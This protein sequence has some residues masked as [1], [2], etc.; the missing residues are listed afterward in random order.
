MG[1]LPPRAT[2]EE[3]RVDEEALVNAELGLETRLSLLERK[4]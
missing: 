4:S 2:S 1:V 3:S